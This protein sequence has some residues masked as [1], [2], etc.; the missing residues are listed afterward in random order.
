MLTPEGQEIMLDTDFAQLFDK[1]LQITSTTLSKTT[2][3]FEDKVI[4]HNAVTMLVGILMF[5]PELY[6]RFTSY[7]NAG[8]A[9]SNSE[10]LVLAGLL[11]SEE[12]VRH[13]FARSLESLAVNLNS[14]ESNPLHFLLGVQA[15][16]FG[17]ISNRPSRQFFELFNALIDLKAMRDDLA[18]EAAA[19]SSAI[20]NPEDLLSQII[21]KIKAQQKIK[22]EAGSEQVEE[23][24]EDE[25]K[26]LELAAEQERL[27][28]GLITL[29]GKIIAKADKSVSDR[30]IQDKDLIGQIFKEFLFASYFQAQMD[31]AGSDSIVL[32]QQKGSRTDKKKTAVQNNKSREAAYELLHQLIKNSTALMKT[33]L[34]EQLVPLITTIKKPKTWNYVPQVQSERT[35]TYVGLRNLGCICYMN[36]MMQQFFMIPAFRY[37]LLC[38]NDGKPEDFKEYKGESIDDSMM[39]QL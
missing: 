39:H 24:E 37:N 16:N 4:L 33:F 27:L 10:Q 17:S 30:I 29:T 34:N 18:G 28:V 15:R 21:D 23:T 7:Q 9:I 13:D 35:Q 19:D 5:K 12:K 36:S 14:Q 8:S 32:Y 26:A 38:V 20:Y 25:V 3:I 1:L 2:L 6:A 22:Q 11:C 31:S